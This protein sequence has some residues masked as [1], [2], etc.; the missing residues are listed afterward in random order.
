MAEAP[1]AGDRR[2]PLGRRGG[3][4]ARRR[5]STRNWRATASTST[6]SI[7]LPRLTVR[8]HV[9]LPPGSFHVHCTDV[10]GEWLVAGDDDGL[11]VTRQHAKGDAALRGPAEAILLRLWNRDSTRVAELDEVGDPAI[12]AA[13]LALPGM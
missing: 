13:W 1:G 6:S 8:E 11:R 7:A 12:A 10:A 9:E 3:G 4:R 5:R 2:P